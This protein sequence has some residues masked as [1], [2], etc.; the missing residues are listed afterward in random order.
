LFSTRPAPPSSSIYR[1]SYLQRPWF[2]VSDTFVDLVLSLRYSAKIEDSSHT[3]PVYHCAW[4]GSSSRRFYTL[5]NLKII[6]RGISQVASRLAIPFILNL[7]IGAR[8][9]RP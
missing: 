6:A 8:L 7:A 3:P 2:L 5:G 4:L 9:M 1:V